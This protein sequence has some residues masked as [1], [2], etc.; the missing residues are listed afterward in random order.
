M[1]SQPMFVKGLNSIRF[2]CASWV[3]MDH[4]GIL[5]IT[6]GIDK[7][8]T[9][10]W[11]A[12]GL[13]R[14]LFSGPAA[15]IVFFVISGICIHLPHAQNND[16]PSLPS[17]FARRFLRIL[18]PMLVAILL[19]RYALDVKLGLFEA[20]I[21]WSLLA[22]LMYYAIYP[23]VLRLH[24]AGAPWSA[25]L[26]TS[27]IAALAVV[28]TNPSAVNYPSYGAELNWLLGLPC[29][30]VGCLVADQIMNSPNQ[31]MQSSI[32]V[33][34]G[35]ILALSAVCTIARFH[36]PIGYPWT[37]NFFALAVGAWLVREIWR[38]Q[39]KPPWGIL[40]WAGSW[41]YSLYLVHVPAITL[42]LTLPMPD[43]DF[44]AKWG[45]GMIFILLTALAFAII[46]EFPS[47]SF[48]IAIAKL[49]NRNDGF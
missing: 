9:L 32:W 26:F 33:W 40:E 21:L 4:F 46:V 22:E 19:G 47:H 49:I 44:F 37:L 34:R 42:L 25:L 17:Y 24:R 45:I 39:R 20:T 29:W 6:S 30:L 3:V 7:T 2:L 15:V 48:A 43:L 28:S 5:Q 1:Q 31:S 11:L 41:S 18:S 36:S 10:G 27:F 12:N 35:G 16:I 13:V 8:T 23:L 38:F 14:S